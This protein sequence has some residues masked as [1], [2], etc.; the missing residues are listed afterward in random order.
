MLAKALEWVME[1]IA[2]RNDTKKI[3]A[4]LDKKNLSL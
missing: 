1:D 2:G 3:L 4:F